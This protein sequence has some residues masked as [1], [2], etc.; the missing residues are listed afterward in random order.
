MKAIAWFLFASMIV[1]GGCQSEL[2]TKPELEQKTD[3]GFGFWRVVLAEPVK[4]KFESIG[5]FEY[6]YYGNL[7]LC[8]VGAYSISPSGRYAI[9]QDGPSGELFLFRREEKRVTRLTSHFI[10]LADSFTWRE[11]A[12][13]VEVD[14]GMGH[15]VERFGL[16]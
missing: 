7:R 3:L 11:E 10:A 1:F 15:G 8:Q 13:C 12:N 4:S 14:F 16:R 9:Y 6:L 2:S 5:H